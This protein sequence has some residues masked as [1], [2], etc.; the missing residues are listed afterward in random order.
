MNC[1]SRTDPTYPEGWNQNPNALNADAT[2]NADFDHMANAKF[3]RDHRIYLTDATPDT[4]Q[5]GEHDAHQLPHSTKPFDS[6]DNPVLGEDAG[7]NAVSGSPSRNDGR[8]S[9][10]WRFKIH[11]LPRNVSR[12]LLKYA[13]FI[14]PGFMVSVAYIDPGTHAFTTI[15]LPRSLMSCFRCFLQIQATLHCSDV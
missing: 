2:T 3:Q 7:A 8:A 9:S 13:K 1:P 14:G 11:N 5:L 12:V 15:S 10:S 4:I 6:Q